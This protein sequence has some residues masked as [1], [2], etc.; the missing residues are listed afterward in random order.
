[1]QRQ[2]VIVDLRGGHHESGR[3]GQGMSTTPKR[4]IVVVEDDP[5]TRKLL[6]RQLEAAG[7]AVG[8]YENGRVAVDPI[9]EMGSGM[10][11]ADWS[12]PEM[13]GLELCRAVRELEG[14]QAVSNVYFLLLT[15]HS[16][17]DKVVEGLEAGA[18]DYLTKPYH[19]GEL[20]AR[21]QVGQRMLALQEELMQRNV[22]VQ[23]ANAK[24]ALLANRLETLAN[25]DGL[26]GLVNRRCLLNRF[27]EAWAAAERDGHTLSCFMFDVD[28]FKRINDTYGHS[29][30][31]EV[32]R[33]V[34]ATA[35]RHARRPE[36]CGRFGGEEFMLVFPTISLDD[37][38]AV[39]EQ[40][41]EAIHDAPVSYEDQT[42]PV[43]VS[44][45]VAQR[46]EAT[47]TLDD[48]ITSADEM[49]YKAKDSGRNQTWVCP[50]E[51]APFCAAGPAAPAAAPAD[52]SPAHALQSAHAHPGHQ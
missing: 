36:L 20:L 4:Q 30:G 44:I 46:C 14:M 7:Y 16:A 28:K 42:I 25:T 8:A 17:K 48:L 2:Y 52:G 47:A 1:M 29:A 34:S 12:M 37:V 51:G 33:V 10:V 15:A 35:K 27:N 41:R 5:A 49:L 45:G 18:N 40:L 3:C 38:V 11:I 31:D 32:L 9:I 43:S 22:E 24:M 39:A 21:V 6:A 19:Q 50:P 26:T 23:K 13:D